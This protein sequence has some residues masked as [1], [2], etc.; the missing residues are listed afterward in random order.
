[1]YIYFVCYFFI[2]IFGFWVKSHTYDLKSKEI[3]YGGLVATL[4]I[5]VSGMR[6]ISIGADTWNY[7]ENFEIVIPKYS[8]SVLAQNFVSS[9]VDNSYENRDVG[10]YFFAKTI[11]LFTDDGRVYLLLIAVLIMIPIVWWIIKYSKNQCMSYIS[12]LCIFFSFMGLTGIRQALALVLVSVFG[13]KYIRERKFWS[14]LVLV[15]LA[16]TL[17]KTAIIILPL[18]FVAN[19]HL[20]KLYR[21]LAIVAIAICFAGKNILQMILN[22]VG[23]YDYQQYEGA[24]TYLFSMFVLLILVWSLYNYEKL[25]NQNHNNVHYINA[26]IVGSFMLPLSY[27]NPTMLRLTYYYYF[28]LILLIP[29]L[30]TT[31]KE[32]RVVKL[33]IYM[34]LAIMM[35]RNVPEYLFFWEV[36]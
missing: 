31:F 2:I 26:I 13:Y 30:V 20:T 8:W 7:V 14:F 1:M 17:H 16:V 15:V 18:Y 6:D 23:G 22:R 5:F 33:A 10:Y 34:A 29:E 4:L 25:V 9:F 11:Q 21:F 24:G 35:T 32:K 36:R 27:I 19:I 28:F 3:A 12:F